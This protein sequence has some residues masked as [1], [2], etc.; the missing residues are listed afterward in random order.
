MFTTALRATTPRAF[1][2]RALTVGFA[3]AV[4]AV[5]ASV[6]TDAAA[7]AAPETLG[8]RPSLLVSISLGGKPAPDKHPDCGVC[9][10]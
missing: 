4:I 2:R 3:M 7:Q 1:V 10:L 9:I 5:A 8:A 6:S